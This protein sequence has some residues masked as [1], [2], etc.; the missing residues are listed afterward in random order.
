MKDKRIN[1]KMKDREKI[2]KVKNEKGIMMQR[3]RKQWILKK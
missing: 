1:E 3:E 2:E